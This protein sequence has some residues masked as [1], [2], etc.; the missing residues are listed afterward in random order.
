M[1][2]FEEVDMGHTPL[3][4]VFR[5]MDLERRPGRSTGSSEN[6]RFNIRMNG[7]RRAYRLFFEYRDIREFV[8][9]TKRQ[10]DVMS[11]EELTI[12]RIVPLAE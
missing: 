5:E 12:V 2:C 11:G 8:K 9:R 1:L 3:V 10:L 6:I 4:V 7:R